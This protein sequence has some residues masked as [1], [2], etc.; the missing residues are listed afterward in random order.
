[1]AATV[2][3]DYSA[4]PEGL[5]GLYSFWHWLEWQSN[6]KISVTRSFSPRIP[7]HASEGG[8]FGFEQTED[9]F[10]EWIMALTKIISTNTV[11]K[12]IQNFSLTG[13]YTVQLFSTQSYLTESL[14]RPI[15]SKTKALVTYG[16]SLRYGSVTLL[17]YSKVRWCMECVIVSVGVPLSLPCIIKTSGCG[18]EAYEDSW[19]EKPI[20]E[21]YTPFKTHSSTGE[22][23]SPWV[24]SGNLVWGTKIFKI[25]P[26]EVASPT[27]HSHHSCKATSFS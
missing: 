13:G 24:V 26:F 5:R 11:L 15:N 4:S 10:P 8:S 20:S 19:R 18:Q 21:S 16:V 6:L 27:Y 2:F 12:D 9:D 7:D 1:M 17:W 22:I 25:N 3:S 14:Q 23:Q